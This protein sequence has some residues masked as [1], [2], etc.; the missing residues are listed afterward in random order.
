MQNPLQIR[1]EKEEEN[2]NLSP[3]AK[4]LLEI[5]DELQDFTA[6]LRKKLLTELK[7]EKN[8]NENN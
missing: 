4:Q 7:P 3:E 1:V 5:L 2:N 6:K 8:Q